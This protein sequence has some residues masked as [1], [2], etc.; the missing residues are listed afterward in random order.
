MA[1]LWTDLFIVAEASAV[2]T[3]SVSTSV[4]TTRDAPHSAA[5]KPLS[6][7]PQPSSSTSCSAT[8]SGC[9]TCERHGTECCDRML[10]QRRRK[11]PTDRMRGARKKTDG[12]CDAF[13]D[14][15]ILLLAPRQT[16]IQHSTILEHSV[17]RSGSQWIQQAAFR[18]GADC[19]RGRSGYMFADVVVLQTIQERGHLS[20]A[21]GCWLWH[22]LRSSV[23]A[24]SAGEAHKYGVIGPTARRTSRRFAEASLI[25][26]AICHTQGLNA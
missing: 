14:E 2:R 24:H 17:L 16:A 13:A 20:T 22:R 26:R 21:D 25:A 9:L 19:H 18:H 11:I 23:V 6:P 4:S 7:R 5:V 10:K 3:A 12:D 15:P 8:H 1:L